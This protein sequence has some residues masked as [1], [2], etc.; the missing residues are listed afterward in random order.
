MCSK[1]IYC[2]KLKR[3]ETA[4]ILYRQ[5]DPYDI[6]NGQGYLNLHDIISWSN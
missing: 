1:D 4:K 6:V 3:E 5:L 2:S